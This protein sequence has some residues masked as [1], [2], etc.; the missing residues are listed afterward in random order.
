MN[1]NTLEEYVNWRTQWRIDYK[2]TSEI[3]RSIKAERKEA[4]RNRES[5]WKV[6]AQLL[7]RKSL[8]TDL[9][10]QRQAAKERSV[11]IWNELHKA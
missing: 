1:I 7:A 11:E 6:D 2:E 8:A 10:A 9:L 3:I 5:T 4:S